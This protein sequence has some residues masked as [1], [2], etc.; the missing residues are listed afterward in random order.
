MGPS[1]TG[2]QDKSWTP[3]LL[4]RRAWNESLLIYQESFGSRP[5]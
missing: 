4:A 5:N 1:S 2:V 3:R